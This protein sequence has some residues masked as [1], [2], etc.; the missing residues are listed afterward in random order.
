MEASF[1]VDCRDK[2]GL[3]TERSTNAWLR[4]YQSIEAIS[5]PVT[6]LA[7]SIF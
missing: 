1:N 5:R 7:G 4:I 2:A 3:F 6:L